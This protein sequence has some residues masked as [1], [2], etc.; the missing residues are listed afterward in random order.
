[1]SVAVGRCGGF[2]E[3]VRERVGSMAGFS[4][5]S[6]LKHRGNHVN[7][8]VATRTD[9]IHPV[10]WVIAYVG[11]CN[12]LLIFFSFFCFVTSFGYN[13]F[14]VG[15]ST[16]RQSVKQIVNVTQINLCGCRW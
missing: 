6:H 3:Y 14:F 12:P 15:I 16:S 11:S 13:S 8:Q 9:D 1:M 4:R 2:E 7:V 10:P 5:F